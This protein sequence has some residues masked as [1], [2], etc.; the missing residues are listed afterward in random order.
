MCSHRPD[1]AG[2]RQHPEIGLDR[3]RPPTAGFDPCLPLPVRPAAP[4][5]RPRPCTTG[6]P[7]HPA[8]VFD[9]APVLCTM[10]PG[11]GRY[12]ESRLSIAPAICVIRPR[13]ARQTEA[14]AAP[15]IDIPGC[16]WAVPRCS[17]EVRRG[18]RHGH[19]YDCASPDCFQVRTNCGHSA[20][21]RVVTLRFIVAKMDPADRREMF[22]QLQ[23]SP[24]G[25]A[26]G[27]ARAVNCPS[28]AIR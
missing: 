11:L 3:L 25:N 14:S 12:T 28:E 24:D 21:P 27:A 4:C 7:A 5:S 17:A 2:R 22:R 18:R 20:H 26:S 13:A 19:V 23:G 16:C 6:H 15:P 9:A 8:G 10:P 1:I